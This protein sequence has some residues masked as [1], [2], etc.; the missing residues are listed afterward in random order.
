M[1]NEAKLNYNKSPGRVLHNFQYGEVHANIWGL[2]FHLNQYLG[3]VNCNMDKDSI[4]RVH[5]SEKRKNRG[6]TCG[7][8]KY[9]TIFGVSKTLGSIFGGQQGNTGM[10]QQGNTGP[11]L[12]VGEYPLGINPLPPPNTTLIQVRESKMC[13][14]VGIPFHFGTLSRR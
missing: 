13:R 9:W 6:V 8:L 5:K 11:V 10:D 3:P 2:K 4:F 7:S 12:K 1:E 14:H